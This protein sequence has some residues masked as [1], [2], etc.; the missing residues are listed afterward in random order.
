MLTE[1]KTPKAKKTCEKILLA[2]K[3]IFSNKGFHKTTVQDI[4]KKADVGYGTFYLYFRDKKDVFYELISQV[5][6]ALY[7]VAGRGIDLNK[8]YKPGYSSYRALRKDLKALLLSFLE[9]GSLLKISSELA[10][11]DEDFK[12]RY[13]QM[14][15][16]LM[17]R[18]EKILEKS[19]IAKVNL[20]VAAVAISGMIEAV[21]MD[22]IKG[23]SS[24][25]QEA[26][27]EEVLPTITKLYFKAVT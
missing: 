26:V 10:A 25:D 22:F 1:P 15:E 6:D 7:T 3:E 18:T 2:A 19:N 11:T 17:Q 5:E 14:R 8:D 20:R 4:S 21:A 23:D 13:E 12:H 16:R 27:L 9:H 24:K